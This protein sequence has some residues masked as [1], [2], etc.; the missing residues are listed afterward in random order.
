MSGRRRA[1]CELYPTKLQRAEFSAHAQAEWADKG[2]NNERRLQPRLNGSSLATCLHLPHKRPA[3]Y[4]LPSALLSPFTSLL[5]AP[6]ALALAVSS[7]KAAHGDASLSL[8][9][10]SR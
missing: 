8:T 6:P 5:R 1:A 10:K 3:R 7:L 4:C 2:Q 9:R